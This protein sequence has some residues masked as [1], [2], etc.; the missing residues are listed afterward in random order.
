MMC[1]LV[2]IFDVY[3]NPCQVVYITENENRCLIATTTEKL[4][5]SGRCDSIIGEFNR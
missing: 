4:E 1:A 2:L 3:I 5:F